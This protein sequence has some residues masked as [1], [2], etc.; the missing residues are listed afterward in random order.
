MKTAIKNHALAFSAFAFCGLM[1]A[2]PMSV[3]AQNNAVPMAGLPTV[4][5]S[6]SSIVPTPSGPADLPPPVVAPNFGAS[7][8]GAPSSGGIMMD[9]SSADGKTP[10]AVKDVVKRLSHQTENVTVEDLNAAKE[11]VARL[12]AL[13]DIEKRLSDL[14]EIRRERDELSSAATMLPAGALPAGALPVANPLM[15]A[16]Q[17]PVAPP[18][19]P[20]DTFTTDGLQ[21][22]RL[23]ATDNKFTAYIKDG[24]ESTLVRV[25]DKLDNG[26]K[27]VAI[28][29]N[30]VRI[31]KGKKERWIYLKNNPAMVPAAN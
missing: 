14:E 21:V 19:P 24:S 22:E 16:P 11:A 2:T 25:G 4:N 5:T 13:I 9:E 27:V 7:I 31:A 30:G 3:Q 23:V 17:A 28:T 26:A 8:S 20:V 1:L 29:R 15:T 10:S 6:A 18:P 12:D